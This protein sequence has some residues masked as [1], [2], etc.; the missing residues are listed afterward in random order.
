MALVTVG[1][2]LSKFRRNVK[3]ICVVPVSYTHLPTANSPVLLVLDGHSTH[4]RNIDIINLA[5]SNNVT[6]ICIPPHKLQP[7]DKTFMGPLKTNYSEEVRKFLRHSSRPLSVF[8]IIEL[9]GH[10]YLKVQRGDIAVNGF[11]VTGIYPV[12][13]NIFSDEDFL[14]ASRTHTHPA[15]DKDASV[16]DKSASGDPHNTEKNS[17]QST[18]TPIVSV[19]CSSKT[20]AISGV[21]NDEVVDTSKAQESS[22]KSS[23]FKDPSENVRTPPEPVACSSNFVLPY[24]ISPPP[25]KKQT[26]MRGRKPGTSS[27]LTGSP[28]KTQLETDLSAKREKNAKKDSKGVKKK[29]PKAEN[30]LPEKKIKLE[31]KHSKK[32]FT[33]ESSSDDESF[34]SVVSSELDFVPS[35]TLDDTD[36]DCLFCNGKFSEDARGEVW[37]KCLSCSMWAHLDCA[38]AEKTDYICDFCR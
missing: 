5:R 38:G 9:F 13:R 28:Y 26:S 35:T 6:I 32:L 18:C 34:H 10:A 24:Q 8:D 22:Q 25:P 7:L 15:E 16:P 36:A 11:K 2:N 20:S 30:P 17:N 31:K 3:K 29:P 23:K 4:K 37:V 1:R 12:N 21:V 14:A 19:P 27:I 33:T